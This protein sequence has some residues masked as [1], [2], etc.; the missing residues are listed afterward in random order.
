MVERD[1]DGAY[2]VKLVEGVRVGISSTILL[3][4]LHF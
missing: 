3:K 4:G 1:Q 2:W